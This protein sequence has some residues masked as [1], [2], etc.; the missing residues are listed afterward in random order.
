MPVCLTP[1]P[2]TWSQADVTDAFRI[3][4]QL[5]S[6]VSISDPIDWEYVIERWLLHEGLD[7]NRGSKIREASLWQTHLI[8]EHKLNLFLQIDPYP[9]P[10]TGTLGSK[11]PIL[12]AGATFASPLIRNAYRQEVLNRV[13]WYKPQMLC[14]AM[15]I[16]SYAAENPGDFENFVTTFGEVKGAVAARFGADAPLMFTSVQWEQLQTQPGGWSVLERLM[17]VQ[18]AVGVS[19]YP[20]IRVYAPRWIPDDY[21]SRFRAHAHKPFVFAELGW[22]TRFLGGSE[23]GQAAFVQRFGELTRG[24][25][26]LCANWIALHDGAYGPPFDSMGLFR[27][28]GVPKPALA[29]WKSLAQ[30]R[31]REGAVR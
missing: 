16:N 23:A 19:T 12:H 3:A 1:T 31:D 4:A 30:S 18:D 27:A 24:M 9:T 15:E 8:R 14:L 10:R 6:W 5:G 29:S 13:E 11:L 28:D 2:R 20:H 7:C 26:V 25:N 17:A 22:P 21:Y